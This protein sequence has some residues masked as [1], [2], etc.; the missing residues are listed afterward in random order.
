MKSAPGDVIRV[1]VGWHLRLQFLK[2]KKSGAVELDRGYQT[3]CSLLFIS[4]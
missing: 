3:D 1:N 2:W 4:A